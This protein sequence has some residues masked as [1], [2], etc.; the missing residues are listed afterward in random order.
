MDG[1]GGSDG[2]GWRSFFG[3]YLPGWVGALT[4][5]IALVV[6]GAGG[7]AIANSSNSQTTTTVTSTIT[8]SA[9]GQG[10]ATA[11]YLS[12]LQPKGGDIPTRGD[13]QMG[14]QDFKHSI[15]YD[16]INQS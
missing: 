14:D 7:A 9:K 16:N 13:T 8:T 15:F 12:D 2:R 6:G 5:V 4:G 10:G 3:S 11:V 1:P